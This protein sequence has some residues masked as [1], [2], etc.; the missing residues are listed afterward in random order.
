MVITIRNKIK[1]REQ[2]V[3]NLVEMDDTILKLN[4]TPEDNEAFFPTLKFRSEY[5]YSLMDN[6][7][8]CEKEEKGNSRI[9]VRRQYVLD[10]YLDFD[11]LLIRK[12][13]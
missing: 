6:L 1:F 5:S 9:K 13:K 12:M 8:L 2:L 4:I 10:L 11:V 3:L 7:K